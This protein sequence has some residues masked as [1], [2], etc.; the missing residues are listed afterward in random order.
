[1]AD[2]SAAAIQRRYLAAELA[3]VFVGFDSVDYPDWPALLD[4]LSR[5]A[6]AAGWRGPLVLDEFPYL[7][8]GAAELP[9]VLQRWLDHER[10]DGGLVLAVAGSSQRMM[11]SSI[12]NAGSPLYGR[13]DEILRLAPLPAGTVREALGTADPQDALDGY[14]CWGGV[15][16]YW[17]LAQPFGSDSRRAADELVLSPLGPLHDELD[18]LLR[19]EMP[20]AVPLRPLL[21]AIGQGAHRSNEIA[22]RLQTSATS[23][24]RGLRDLQDLG[25]VR[26]E[27][28]YG[29]DERHSKTSTYSLADPFQRLWFRVVAPHRGYLQS[30]GAAARR[31]VLADAWPH[32]RAKAWEELCRQAVPRLALAGTEWQPAARYWNAARCEWDVVSVSLD[33]SALLLGECR[34]LARAARQTDVDRCVHDLL[35][36]PPPTLP[37][38]PPATTRFAVFV[39]AVAEARRSLPS[40]VELVDCDRVLAA[41]QA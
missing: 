33:G 30:A 14:T 9:S 11:H 37:G 20:S 24:T 26:R 25:Y 15:P 5:E 17:E 38:R 8:W 6:H 22:A 29:Q 2:E 1:V 40:Q 31:A 3:R 18:R 4:R 41:L 34:S 16:R 7:V 32:L 27:V 21:D 19:Q 36:R 28:P 13:A 35:A 23:L 39:P 12:L 10:R